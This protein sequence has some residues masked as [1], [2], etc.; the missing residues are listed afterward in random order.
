MN[1]RLC[2]WDL[3]ATTL[4]AEIFRYTFIYVPGIFLVLC[5]TFFYAWVYFSRIFLRLFKTLRCALVFVT[6]LCPKTLYKMGYAYSFF[7]DLP[8]KLYIL[9]Y[10]SEYFSELFLW[11]TLYYNPVSVSDIYLQL[12]HLVGYEFVHFRDLPRTMLHDEL[13]LGIFCFYLP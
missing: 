6:G 7:L 11:Y 9:I 2:F 1:L 3:R 4:H 12:Y 13:C 10:A 5:Y 8:P